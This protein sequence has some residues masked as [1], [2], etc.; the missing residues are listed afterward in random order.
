[1][2][3]QRSHSH[4]VTL[5]YFRLPLCKAVWRS[6]KTS[7]RMREMFD[8]FRGRGCFLKSTCHEISVLEMQLW[9]RNTAVDLEIRCGE[10][11]SRTIQR[12]FTKRNYVCHIP[13]MSLVRQVH[14]QTI[15]R[16]AIK[17]LPRFCLRRRGY[18]LIAI[19]IRRKQP[20]DAFLA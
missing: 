15:G 3:R 4:V 1:M 18:L 12:P 20:D 5:E 14:W 2:G 11:E 6:R 7:A 10:V 17:V 9:D 8:N 13:I 16:G 19:D